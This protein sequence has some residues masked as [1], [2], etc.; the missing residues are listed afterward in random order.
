MTD[1]PLCQDVLP[2]ERPEKGAGENA[3]EAIEAYPE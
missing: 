1:P 2:R 3:K